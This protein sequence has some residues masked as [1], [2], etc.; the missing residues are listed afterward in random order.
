MSRFIRR[1]V[2]ALAL[3][4]GLGD[5]I[6]AKAQAGEHVDWSQYIESPSERAQPIKNAPASE[7]VA[8]APQKSKAKAPR[9]K[10]AAKPAKAKQKPAARRKR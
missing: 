7:S 3:V 10:S 5:L 9:A 6:E 1:C 8:A 2:T 4:I